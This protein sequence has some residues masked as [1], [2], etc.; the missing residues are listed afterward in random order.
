MRS[1]LRR[2]GLLLLAAAVILVHSLLLGGLAEL[3]P[4]RAGASIER[5]SADFVTALPLAAAPPPPPAAAPAPPPAAD[6]LAAARPA[7][8]PASAPPAE[9]PPVPPLPQ[10]PASS[11][12]AASSPAEPD[13]LA[14]GGPPPPEPSASRPP[15]AAA[16]APLL[17]ASAPPP[18]ASAAGLPVLASA[19]SDEGEL[20]GK[21]LLIDGFA[22]PGST[23]IR[24][25]L[26]GDVRGEVHGTA[27]VRWLREGRRYQVHLDVT[28]GPGFAPLLQRHTTSAG[29]ITRQGLMP[30]HYEERTRIAFAPERRAR[31]DFAPGRVTLAQG[32]QVEVPPD[33]Q[34]GASQFIQLA[35]RFARQAQALA[36]GDAVDI[37]LALPRR[38]D[39]WIY[40]VLALEPVDTPE[41]PIPAWHLR[42]RRSGDPSTYAIEAWLAP[43]LR[44]MPV[45]MRVSDGRGNRLDLELSE[46]LREVPVTS[47][48][49]SPASQTLK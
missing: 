16:S 9:P 44:W 14:Q 32:R 20:V 33:V 40:D 29:R 42:P 45:R 37:T 10:L 8:P 15:P 38:V 36:V 19:A 46:R 31:V 24:Y 34:D 28:V 41:G 2:R 18:A 27:A 11:P 21:E 48:P 13:L 26:G 25:R 47:R 39:G 23:E 1:L 6:P 3:L 7:E 22:W 17:A 4:A 12:R 30:E 35:W 5:M 43:S 49:A